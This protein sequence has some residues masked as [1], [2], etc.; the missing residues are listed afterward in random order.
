[1][2][3]KQRH[4]ILSEN[5]EERENLNFK[6]FL[7]FEKNKIMTEEGSLFVTFNMAFKFY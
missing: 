1:M 6:N 7:N 3:D 2:F 5:I 4:I